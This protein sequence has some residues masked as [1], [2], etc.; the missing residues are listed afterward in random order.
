MVS[1]WQAAHDLCKIYSFVFVGICF[2]LAHFQNGEL[3]DE[4]AVGLDV[5]IA[6]DSQRDEMPP[7]LVA[8]SNNNVY[9]GYIGKGF[10]SD[11]KRTF[12]AIRK[13]NSEEVG[14]A[15]FAKWFQFFS[16]V[17][18]IFHQI[19]LVET[20]ECSLMSYHYNNCGK[21]KVETT[22]DP[23][24]MSTE[25]ARRLLFKEFGGKKAMKVLDRKEKMKINVDVVKD[26]LDKTLLGEFW[27]FTSK[28]KMCWHYFLLF[29]CQCRLKSNR[30]SARGW[31]WPCKRA[32]GF[33]SRRIGAKNE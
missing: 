24:N 4:F 17:W 30:C 6:K 21:Q 10:P 13:K 27:A 16:I 31:I 1:I 20:V 29:I 23:T 11:L 22:N 19:K 15:Y 7:V 14:I 32:T 18:F 28:V 3:S 26:Q 25:S 12:I 5:C 8:V 2:Y 9:D 33:G